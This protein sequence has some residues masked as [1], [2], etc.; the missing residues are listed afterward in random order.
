MLLGI[1]D[2][3]SRPSIEIRKPGGGEPL[4]FENLR[5]RAL[6]HSEQR[7]EVAMTWIVTALLASA[8]V[9]N[10]QRA[11]E[12]FSKGRYSLDGKALDQSLHEDPNMLLPALTLMANWRWD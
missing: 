6:L 11:N 9:L 7:R 2:A 1:G 8:A 3:A 10:Y 4:R 12:L 5:G